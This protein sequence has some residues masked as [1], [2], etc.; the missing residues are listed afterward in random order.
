MESDKWSLTLFQALEEAEITQTREKVWELYKNAT[1]PADLL[2]LVDTIDAHLNTIDKQVETFVKLV[3]NRHQ[4]DI[5]SIELNR[6]N[7]FSTT[8]ENSNHLTTIF[9]SANRLGSS[10]TIKIK[11]LDHEI[12]NVSKTL[13]F[14]VDI[15]SLKNNIDQGNYAI[16]HKNWELAAQ[17]IHKITQLDSELVNGQFA[18]VVI[19]SSE[20]PKLPAD[21]I[22]EWIK[23]LTQVFKEKFNEAASLKNVEELTK[24]FQLFPLISQEET[25]LICYSKFICQIIIET[26]KQLISSIPIND[27]KP[28]LYSSV[29]VQLFENISIMLSQH[30]PLIKKYYCQSYPTAIEFV[31]GKIQGEI[32]SLIGII[33]DTLFDNRRINKL[34]Q[35]IRLYN[36]PIL[37]KR[38]QQLQGAEV[39]T[40]NYVD[41]LV[42]VVQVGDIVHEFATIFHHWSLYCKFI[43]I[44]YLS[45]KSDTTQLPTLIIN[46]QFT[47]KIHDKYLPAFENLYTFYFRRS[48]EKAISIEELPSLDSY[49]HT[50]ATNPTNDIP[51]SSVIEDITLILNN[52]LRDVIDSSI[53]S[54]V[55]KFISGSYQ[56]IQQDLI[57]GFF[58]KS[59]NEN[60]P[61]YNQSLSLISPE[62]D[63]LR[64]PSVSRSA[65]PEPS[66]L[67]FLK[68]AASSALGN[69]VTS[70]TVATSNNPKLVKFA[71][72]LNS[73]AIGQE[74]FNKVFDKLLKDDKYLR[75]TFPFG[76]DHEIVKLILSN[77]FI[78]PFNQATTKIM[79]DSLLNLY[80]QSFRAK[81]LALINDFIPDSVDSNYV[82]FS[83]ND[84]ESNEIYVRFTSGWQ[85]LI[86]P[87]Q[88][89]FHKTL[90]R[91]L[92]RLLVVNISNIIEKKL[93]SVLQKYK[94][95]ELGSIKLERDLSYLIN[96][97]CE[98]NYHLREK[99]VRLTQIVLLVGMDD[100]EYEESIKHVNQN[101]QENTNDEFDETLGINWVLTPLER[102]KIRSF[103]V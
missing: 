73:V 20:I 81:I 99:F 46:S 57:N 65:T 58:I 77:D 37:T 6:A 54:T 82:V 41:E 31:I 3:S 42:S 45:N 98:D 33:G 32:D 93:N 79:S 7:K 63:N 60:T 34:I 11:S 91:K 23:Q 49:L 69:V 43:T 80:N 53:T 92:L 100:E 88:R 25:G 78:D 15:Q 89:T 18:S 56:V 22:D 10:L 29:A 35:D 21:I 96:E 74:Y 47:K 72:Y 50:K 4:K 66:S 87:Y 62:A 39:S 83:L 90:T 16:H 44:K 2:H 19:P 8:I 17:C 59:L 70:S 97:V 27:A 85:A 13:D 67:G 9:Q 36:Y 68:G 48:L 55:K 12:K 26:Q 40:V 86:K 94:I 38:Y 61:R 30:A 5:N 1:K 76:K 84:Q 75:N 103:R 64:S 52:S 24:Y 95:S 28:G 101:K 102:K 51:C 14:V 71:I